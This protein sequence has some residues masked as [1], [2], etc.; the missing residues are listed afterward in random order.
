MI[1]PHGLLG[2]RTFDYANIFTN[3]DLSDPSRPLAI[4]PGQLEARPKVV[5]VAT[6]MEPAR[7]LSWIIVWTGLSAAWFIGDG[8]DQG[9]A[10]D[11]TINSEARR[12]LD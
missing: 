12:L 10:I 8:D 11:L 3:S 1:D 5:I 6:G 2:E 9:T 7:L 4:L